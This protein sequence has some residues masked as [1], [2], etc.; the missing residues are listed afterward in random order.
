[1]DTS[2]H[3][4]AVVIPSLNPDSQLASIVVQLREKCSNPIII[5]NDGSDPEYNALFDQLSR[6][7]ENVTVLR[8][9]VNCGKGRAC[10]TAF[11]FYLNTYP[12]GLGV[13]T[14]DADG[15]HSPNDI[16]RGIQELSSHS[17]SLILGCRD[18]S[19]PGVPWKSFWGN[20]ITK[21]V[22][23]LCS[24]K[25]LQD[26]QT[27]LRGIPLAFLKKLLTVNGERFEFE[28]LMLLE[29]V[30]QRI[31]V[32]EYPISTIYLNSNRETHFH[33]IKDS[34]IIYFTI[35]QY[36]FR[37]L[38]SFI[39]SGLLSALIDI[40]LFY[41]FFHFV[42][43]SFQAAVQLAYALTGARLISL[44]FNYMLN[45]NCVFHN[46]YIYKRET[47]PKFLILCGLVLGLAYIFNRCGQILF[48]ML[49]PTIIKIAVDGLLFLFS[50]FVQKNIIFRNR[51]GLKKRNQNV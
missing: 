21:Y 12:D 9:A 36:V 13:V 41:L 32:I 34:L 28:T 51:F 26:T 2:N 44:V 8:H 46:Q 10:K 35:L 17:N 22:Y 4:I 42:F 29:C 49:E 40:L 3:L 11:N 38:F 43:S 23:V 25:K 47:F 5:V 6:E 33:P 39:C 31:P 48:P 37:H 15:Q 19:Q 18:F 24:W 16:L 30:S 14:C 7:N 20:F 50:F 1:M 27:G 45:R